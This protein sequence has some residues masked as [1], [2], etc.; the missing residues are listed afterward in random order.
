M[1]PDGVADLRSR[2]EDSMLSW[3]GGGIGLVPAVGSHWPSC[4]M[5]Y[6][7]SV[8]HLSRRGAAALFSQF[9]VEWTRGSD[10]LLAQLK[11][12]ALGFQMISLVS[13][14]I[15]FPEHRHVECPLV[16]HISSSWWSSS[17]S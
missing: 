17:G 16:L 8:Q 15:C 2:L 7:G 5:Y 3:V 13:L 11:T 9:L 6:A 4:C 10:S 12:L 14:Q 1:F